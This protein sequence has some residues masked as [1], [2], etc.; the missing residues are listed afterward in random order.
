[1]ISFIQILQR[2]EWVQNPIFAVWCPCTEAVRCWLYLY[3]SCRWHTVWQNVTQPVANCVAKLV[4]DVYL[5][6]C[7][8]VCCCFSS[9][10]QWHTYERKKPK[11]LRSFFLAPYTFEVRVYYCGWQKVQSQ[12]CQEDLFHFGWTCLTFLRWLENYRTRQIFYTN[13]STCAQWIFSWIFVSRQKTCRVK[14][15]SGKND[16]LR[17]I[18]KHF[19]SKMI[20][21]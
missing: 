3:G 8:C 17:E 5:F 14:I 18:V 12:T 1:M 7:C 20:K 15:I 9:S 16:M 13:I 4:E 2:Y 11:V 19:S 21:N 10:I 6:I